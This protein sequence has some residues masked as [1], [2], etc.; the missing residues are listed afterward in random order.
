MAHM[1]LFRVLCSTVVLTRV[2][3]RA[4]LACFFVLLPLPAAAPPAQL[5]LPQQAVTTSAAPPPGVNGGPLGVLMPQPV[6]QQQQPELPASQPLS[7]LQALLG[8]PA[9]LSA[10]ILGGA[11]ATTSSNAAAASANSD[12]GMFAGFEQLPATFSAPAFGVAA[13]AA[14]AAAAGFADEGDDPYDPTLEG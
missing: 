11:A 7:G 8:N 2:C 3:V 14:D 4:V 12:A 9:M 5:V 13:P 6:Q 1:C 10:A